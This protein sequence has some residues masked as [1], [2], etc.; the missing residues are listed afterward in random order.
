MYSTHFIA[1]VI[2]SL[3]CITGLREVGDRQGDGNFNSHLGICVWLGNNL[4]FPTA[5]CQKA[6][7]ISEDLQLFWNLLFSIDSAH[8]DPFTKCI[9]LNV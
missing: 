4:T 6:W 1:V 3:L 9:I 7:S 8:W 5:R 2:I